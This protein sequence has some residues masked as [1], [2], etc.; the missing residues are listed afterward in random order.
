MRRVCICLIMAALI[1]GMVGCSQPC[2]LIILSTTG[3]NLSVMKAGT[4]TWIGAQ[5]GMSLEPGDAIRC[6]DSS[7]AAITFV[8][9]TTVELQAGTE[10]EV[11]S[12]AYTGTGSATIVLRQTIGSIIFRITR[13]IDPASH[14]EVLTPAGAVVARGSIM[15]V[16]VIEDGTT[17]VTNLEGDIWAVA[18]GVELQI[19]QGQQCVISP[20]QPPKF[21]MISTY[22]FTTVGLRANGSVVAV[23][24]NWSGQCDVGNWTDI[25]EVAGGGWQT[26]GL[27][28]NGTVVVVGC[29][30]DDLGQCNVSEWTEIRQIA[31][32]NAH[33][34]GIKSD[35]TVVAVGADSFGQCDVGNW[36]GIIQVTAAGQHTVGLRADGTV[37][38]VGWNVFGQCNVGNWTNI[39][40]VAAGDDHTVGLRAD[41]TV[42]AVGD[43]LPG[44]CNVGNWTNI[45]MIA[46][47][48]YHTVGLRSDGTVI[49][50]GENNWGE[51][52]VGN[53]T[54]IVQVAAGA[55]HTVGLKSDGTV[56]A[57]GHN[58]QG[59]CNV[60]SWDLTP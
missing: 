23:G 22:S 18:Q 4:G 30:G 29:V 60:T 52:N 32:G 24:A 1:V 27:T 57:V 34:V 17:W 14:Y 45:V 54:D 58:D 42:I 38:A 26:A 53:W 16:H 51:C 46:A 50:A 11:D 2:S 8:D 13:I 47:A 9:G 49:A 19:P 20:G 39:I 21:V 35:E 44:Q 25:I 48:A 55:E 37:V 36:T 12:L 41:G 5:V 40:Q 33:T 15:W 10:I 56:V 31:S 43:T 6:G 7:T 28:S 3:G 59:E